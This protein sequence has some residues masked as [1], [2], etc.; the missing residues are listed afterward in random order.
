MAF[1]SLED[2]ENGFLQGAQINMFNMVARYYK[3]QE[4]LE[5]ERF[6]VVD[7]FSLTPRDRFFDSISWRIYTGLERHYYGLSDTLAAH[8]TGGAGVSY[9]LTD[10]SSFYFLGRLRL[11]NNRDISSNLVEP[12]VG[13]EA[14]VLWHFGFMTARLAYVS[15][16]FSHDYYRNRVSYNHNFV[17]SR[18]HA[19]MLNVERTQDNY[20]AYDQFG[21]NYRVHF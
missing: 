17:L 19:L 12:A 2:A 7:I 10:D 20:G 15:E 8:V 1:H 21:V 16:H 4:Q 18:N 3:K 11:E 6:D 13:G 5:I 14:G 9:A